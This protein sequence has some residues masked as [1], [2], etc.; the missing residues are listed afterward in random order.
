MASSTNVKN[1]ISTALQAWAK[2]GVITTE[3][4]TNYLAL[5]RQIVTRAVYT[6]DYEELQALDEILTPIAA[7]LVR[8]RKEIPR[9]A[10]QAVQV[11]VL[12][13]TVRSI[14]FIMEEIDPR[15]AVEL[16]KHGKTV[17]AVLKDLREKKIDPTCQAI[18]NNW[19][20]GL[21]EISE[22][23]LSRT[24]AALEMAGLVLRHGVSGGL[25][26]ELLP[27]AFDIQPIEE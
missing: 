1:K 6:H 10:R 2:K 13:S 14:L 5:L 20:T 15:S 27:K 23:R 11:S 17:I 8:T 18:L 24:L 26:V 9:S 22:T 16:I 12:A 21:E 19:P 25:M 3:L 4:N 7:V